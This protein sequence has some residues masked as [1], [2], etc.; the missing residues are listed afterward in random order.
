MNIKWNH[1]TCYGI[2]KGKMDYSTELLEVSRFCNC[3]H[4]IDRHDAKRGLRN[5]LCIT[6]K[7]TCCIDDLYEWF[8]NWECGKDEYIGTTYETF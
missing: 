8:Q 2:K 6:T 1:R 3:K 7:A 4:C 5:T